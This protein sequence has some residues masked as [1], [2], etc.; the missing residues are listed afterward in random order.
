MLRI[1]PQLLRTNTGVIANAR[2]GCIKLLHNDIGEMS[3]GERCDLTPLNTMN[4]E[5][6]KEFMSDIL[7]RAIPLKVVHESAGVFRESEVD[8]VDMLVN[9]FSAP[10]L[11]R[12][13][14]E[15]ELTLQRIANA[16][17]AGENKKVYDLLYPFMKSTIDKSR[18]KKNT[19]DIFKINSAIN[20]HDLIILQR[21]LQRMPREVFQNPGQLRASIVIPLCNVNNIA[22]VLFQKRSNNV[23][24]YKGQVCFPGGKT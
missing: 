15:R 23:S 17:E 21:R 22:S 12:A 18:L 10:A 13:L 4:A 6:K 1:F 5:L 19:K 24:N 7:S 8:D 11:A 20:K 3:N 2:I 14:R 16:F 9:N